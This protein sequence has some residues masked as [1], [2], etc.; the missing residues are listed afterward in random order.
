MQTCAAEVNAV[1]AI[2]AFTA[3]LFAA[4][5]YAL[6]PLQTIKTPIAYGAMG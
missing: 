5:G 3:A 2:L 4:H 6:K 1:A